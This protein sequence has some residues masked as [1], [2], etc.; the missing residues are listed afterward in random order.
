MPEQMTQ[1]D[2]FESIRAIIADA[3]RVS[4]E[5]I[6]LE[7]NLI[8]ELDA[9]S[10]DI[11]D[12]RFRVEERFDFRVGQEAFVQSI[13]GGDY[14]KLADN[15]TVANMVRFVVEELAEAAKS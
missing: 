10:I 9:E 4:P 15:F 13:A 12:I 11:V 3:L 5:E 8:I 2:V 7:T 1:Q 6:R 14:Q